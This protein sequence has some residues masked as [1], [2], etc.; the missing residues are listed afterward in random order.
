MIAARSGCAG[1]LG[2][3]GAR[4]FERGI[5]SEEVRRQDSH[6]GVDDRRRVAGIRRLPAVVVGRGYDF[7]RVLDPVRALR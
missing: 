3:G 1:A 4:L 5:E 6:R 7:R 2:G